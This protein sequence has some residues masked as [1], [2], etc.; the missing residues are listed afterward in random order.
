MEDEVEDITIGQWFARANKV[1]ED[2]AIE[3]IFLR[4]E[5]ERLKERITFNSQKSNKKY[6]ELI[7]KHNIEIQLLQTTIKQLK[8]KHKKVQKI[9]KIE[10]EITQWNQ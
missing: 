2:E 3:L 8:F 1:K 9:N 7:N 4:E 6:Q 10:R 5:I